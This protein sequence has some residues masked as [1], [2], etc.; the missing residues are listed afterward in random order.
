M[1]EDFG[2]AGSRTH[3]HGVRARRAVEQAREQVARVVGATRGE[4]VFTSG[5]TESNNLAILG[6]AEHGIAVGKRHVVSTRL[7]HHAV[8]GPLEVLASRGF[9]VT[10]VPPTAGGW[11]EPRAVRDAVRDDTLLV[12]VMHVNNETGVVQ[13]VDEVARTLEGH[14]AFLHVDAAQSFGRVPEPLR[15]GRIDLISISGHKVHAPKGVGAL[16][17]RKRDGR[18]PPLSPLMHGGGQELG[19]RPGTLPVHLIAG[20]GLAAELAVAQAQQRV[21]AN[22]RFRRKVLHGLAP[23][24]PVLHGD[25]ARVV[26]H[27]VNLAFPGIDAEDAI[28]ALEGVVAVSTGAACTTSARTCSHVLEAMGVAADRLGGVLRLSWCHMTED[29]DWARVVDLLRPLSKANETR[30]RPASL[31]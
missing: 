25:Q 15:N 3:D 11:V 8:L 31:A 20:L 24:H 10:L 19:L 5:A 17:A 21:E 6:L 14:P 30:T 9:E 16:V 13:P 29:V 22:L 23:L 26:P 4:V 18:R 12:S 2:N 28:E 1:R 27:V 7:E